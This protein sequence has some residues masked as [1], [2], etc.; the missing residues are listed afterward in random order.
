MKR[1]YFFSLNFL[2]FAFTLQA[3]VA[4]LHVVDSETHAYIPG[5]VIHSRLEKNLDNHLKTDLQG[6]VPV[7]IAEDDT[8]SLECKGYYPIHI[9]VTHFQ[10]YDFSHPMRIYMTPLMHHSHHT[11][12]EDL[13]DLQSFEY[14]F[15]HDDF[16][17]KQFKIQVLEHNNATNK[18][19]Q[20]LQ[21][22]RDSHEKGFNIVD[23]KLPGTKKN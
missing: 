1:I 16:E 8:I 18:R 5:V 19:N 9:V 7:H 21:T 10:D 12:I 15:V 3:Q 2:L 23:I 20:W 11:E 17:N 14:H 6:N 13:T 22:T 4:T